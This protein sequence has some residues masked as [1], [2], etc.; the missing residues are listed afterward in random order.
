M[1][2]RIGEA[3]VKLNNNV[4]RHLLLNLKGEQAACRIAYKLQS[5]CIAHGKLAK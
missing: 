1:N 4:S 3:N 5:D 2:R